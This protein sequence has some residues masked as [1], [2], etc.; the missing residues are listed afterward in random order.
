MGVLGGFTRPIGLLRLPVST[1]TALSLDET[2]GWSFLPA[3]RPGGTRAPAFDG[4]RDRLFAFAGNNLTGAWV[5]EG[6]RPAQLAALVLDLREHGKSQVTVLGSPVLD[7]AT[8]D[9]ASVSFAGAPALADRRPARLSLRDVDGDGWLDRE[10]RFDADRITLAP[11]VRLDG[12]TGAGIA[13]VGYGRVGAEATGR[14]ADLD[15]SPIATH[16]DPDAPI[17]AVRPLAVFATGVGMLGVDLP[18]AARVELEIFAV[19]GRRIVRRDLGQLGAGRSE[20][21]VGAGLA[22]G[23]YFARVHAGTESSTSKV[24]IIP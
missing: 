18:S 13:I 16:G 19:N 14:M 8:I 3:T 17:D 2:P 1:L 21:Q 12:R 6:D 15:R 9:P 4:T 22:M 10:F 11:V 23:V 24:L 20:L 5:L 7:V